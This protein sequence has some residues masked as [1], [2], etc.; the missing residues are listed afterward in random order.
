MKDK[1]VKTTIRLWHS[2]LEKIR[3]MF[4]GGRHGEPGLNEVIRSVV[5][6]F[7]QKKVDPKLKELEDVN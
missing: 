4:P 7:V 6:S 1:L 2:D 5:H 3:T